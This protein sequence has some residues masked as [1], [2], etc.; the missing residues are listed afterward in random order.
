MCQSNTKATSFDIVRDC[1]QLEL[2]SIKMREAGVCDLD[3]LETSQSVSQSVSQP[4]ET[5]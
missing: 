5:I 4:I 3:S 2:A 1:F